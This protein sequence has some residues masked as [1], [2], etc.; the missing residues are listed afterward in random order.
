[1]KFSHLL[2]LYLSAMAAPSV[3]AIPLRHSQHCSP[4]SVDVRCIGHNYGQG[5]VPSLYPSGG[6][7]STIHERQLS[8]TLKSIIEG[9]PIIGPILAPLLG[10]LLGAIGL[11]ELDVASALKTPLN[12]EQIATLANFE[13]ALSNAAHKV[14][15]SGGNAEGGAQTKLKAGGTVPLAELAT[16]VPMI[17]PFLQPFVPLLRFLNLDTLDAKP[18]SVFSLALLNENQSAKLAQFQTILRQ[19]VANVLPNVSN[20]PT[21]DPPMPS[22]ASP[23]DDVEPS[24]TPEIPSDA[25]GGEGPGSSA[26]SPDDISQAERQDSTLMTPPAPL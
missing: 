26:S 10:T 14:L 9:L 22:K 4:E 23:S 18:G 15:A 3:L 2:V 19:E 12:V 11:S 20:T 21:S 1:M 6:S 25:S 16:A 5:S 7:P 13:F 24:S 8:Q 17:G